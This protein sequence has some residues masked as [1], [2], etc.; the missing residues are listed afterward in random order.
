L[1]LWKK[2]S[3]ADLWTRIKWCWRILREGL[4]FPAD[5]T[6]ITHEEAKCLGKHLIKVSSLIE[7]E[8]KKW[9]KQIHKRKKNETN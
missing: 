3:E 8:E 4:L 2:G 5:Q 7:K 9:K 1:E 6:V